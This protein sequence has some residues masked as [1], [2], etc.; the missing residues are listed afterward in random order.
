M[1][2]LATAREGV[3]EVMAKAGIDPTAVDVVVLTGGSS[4]IPVFQKMLAK[5][6]PSARLVETDAFSSVTSGLAI[7]AHGVT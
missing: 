5:E 2:A 7:Y 3:R 4:V 6:C 1:D